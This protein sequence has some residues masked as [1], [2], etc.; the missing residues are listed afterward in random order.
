MSYIVFGTRFKMDDDEIMAAMSDENVERIE[1]RFVEGETVE[2]YSAK[3]WRPGIVLSINNIIID[4][5]VKKYPSESFKSVIDGGFDAFIKIKYLFKGKMRK[6]NVL[7]TSKRLAFTNTHIREGD[8][9]YGTMIA[10]MRAE[11]EDIKAMRRDREK[12][13]LT[14]VHAFHTG[15]VRIRNKDTSGPRA[16]FSQYISTK[17]IDSKNIKPSGTKRK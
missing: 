13:H 8:R 9:Y 3:K 16:H 11:P 6:A 7:Q 15:L 10:W 4:E 12:H 1:C 17:T 2:F 14:A 5:R